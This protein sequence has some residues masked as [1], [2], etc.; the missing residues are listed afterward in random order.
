MSKFANKIDYTTFRALVNGLFADAIR[1]NRDF[2][3]ESDLIGHVAVSAGFVSDGASVPRILW[4]IFPP[5]GKYLEAAV[6]HDHFCVLGH[7]GESP[8][9][10]VRAAKVFKEAMQVCGVGWVRRWSMYFAVRAGGPRF[11][12][13][14][15]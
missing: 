13:K 15:V 12:C 2:L 11:K 8:I 10:S 14:K 7:A 3:Y 4:R 5:F 1:L 9:N 6:V